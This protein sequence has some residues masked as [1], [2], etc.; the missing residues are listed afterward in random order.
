MSTQFLDK[1][2]LIEVSQSFDNKYVNKNDVPTKLS[3]LE[4]DDTHKVVTQEEKNIWNNKVDKKEGYGLSKN[5][6]DDTEKSKLN[7]S[8]NKIVFDAP[9][10]SNAASLICTDNAGNTVNI[11]LSMARRYN[12]GLMSST[13]K[14]KLDSIAKGANK[15]T[16]LSQLENDTNFKTESEIQQMAKKASLLKKEVVTSLPT[17]GVDNV[18]YVLEDLNGKDNNVY[19]EYLWID[20]K[21]ELIGSTDVDL[22]QYAKKTEIKTNLSEMIEDSTH[23]TVTDEEK[24]RWNQATDIVDNLESDDSTKPLSAKQGKILFQ[25]ANEGKDKIANALIGKGVDSVSKD[26]SFSDLATG[27]KNIKTNGYVVNSII[28]EKQLEAVQKTHEPDL[29]CCE[30]MTYNNY[31]GKQYL[32]ISPWDSNSV[33]GFVGDVAFIVRGDRVVKTINISQTIHALFCLDDKIRLLY[34]TDDCFCYIDYDNNLDKKLSDNIATNIKSPW[35]TVTGYKENIFYVSSDFGRSFDLY[36]FNLQKIATTPRSTTL[37]TISVDYYNNIVCCASNKENMTKLTLYNLNG[38]QLASVP[39][40]NGQPFTLLSPMLSDTL[41]FGSSDGVYKFT[42]KFEF[43]KISSTHNQLVS[44]YN[45]MTCYE[46]EY[47]TWNNS[48]Q[49]YDEQLH[50]IWNFQAVQQGDGTW[51]PQLLITKGKIYFIDGGNVLY[52]LSNEP[53]I[54]TKYKIIS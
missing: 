2:G 47:F 6:Y 45:K 51:S 42:S 24:I 14:M 16:K 33:V 12:S 50:L 3:Q 54:E 28:S 30:K 32:Q 48:L 40:P 8:I 44:C 19:L 35:N 4:E 41:L 26:S 18:L 25:F 21:F 53:K 31:G 49:K 46:N 38:E 37:Q 52:I 20:N 22:S 7:S 1:Q 23:R 11:N 9:P 39:T 15:T 29:L 34:Q 43:Q 5:D 17:Q 36:D 13:D 10:K 27:I